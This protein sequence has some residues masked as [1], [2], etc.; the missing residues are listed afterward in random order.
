MK[1]KN[2]GE[3]GFR[4]SERHANKL[5][6]IIPREEQSITY[7]LI[8]NKNSGKLEFGLLSELPKEG[9]EY[10]SDP[11]PEDEMSGTETLMGGRAR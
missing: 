3:Q 4:Y 5:V 6:L 10:F 1:Y 9:E 11:R 7:E 2:P 8:E